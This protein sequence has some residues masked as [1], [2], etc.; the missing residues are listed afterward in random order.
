MNIQYRAKIAAAGRK[1]LKNTMCQLTKELCEQ[2]DN[3]AIKIPLHDNGNANDYYR[4][5]GYYGRKGQE[6]KLIK[7]LK[8]ETIEILAWNWPN[9]LKQVNKQLKREMKRFAKANKKLVPLV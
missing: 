7:N 8:D 2:L 5:N 1:N 3:R 6:D 9:I 4:T